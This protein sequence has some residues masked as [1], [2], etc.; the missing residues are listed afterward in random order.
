MNIVLQAAASL[1]RFRAASRSAI[2]KHR[3]TGVFCSFGP[4][5][6]AGEF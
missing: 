4:D 1:A 2:M 6:V 5:A 3:S